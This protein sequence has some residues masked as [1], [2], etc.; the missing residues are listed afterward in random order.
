MNLI[1]EDQT[2]VDADCP[3]RARR[4]FADLDKTIDDHLWAAK[5]SAIE[6][7]RFELKQFFGDLAGKRRLADPGWTH[8]QLVE[9]PLAPAL[10]LARLIVKLA[11]DLVQTDHA[12]GIAE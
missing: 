5:I 2:R 12:Q 6:D 10:G 9:K 7:D 11:S 3:D 4:Y 1:D 8:K